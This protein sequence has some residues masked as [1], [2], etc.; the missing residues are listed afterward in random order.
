MCIRDRDSFA[1]KHNSTEFQAFIAEHETDFIRFKTNLLLED[2]GKDPI[3]R[4]DLIGNLVQSISVIPEAIVRDVYIKMCI[5]DRC[6]LS[7]RFTT[8]TSLR[9]SRCPVSYTHLDVYKRQAVEEITYA[10]EKGIDFIICDHHVPDDI[11]VSYTHL[12]NRY[13]H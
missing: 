7:C 3:K 9:Y 6:C 4:A 1:R 10:K 5:R 11:P 12:R 8:S 2:A 13:A